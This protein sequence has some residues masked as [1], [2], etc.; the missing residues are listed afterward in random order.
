MAEDDLQAINAYVYD[1]IISKAASEN[2]WE[3][4]ADSAAA[5]RQ[6]F[7]GVSDEM[8]I[9]AIA[10]AN[11]RSSPSDERATLQTVD[12]APAPPE[13]GAVW[14]TDARGVRDQVAEPVCQGRQPMTEDHR[15]PGARC[16]T[17]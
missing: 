10:M 1:E 17:M 16:S 15:R 14:L 3:F 12:K 6:R 2:V 9:D 8:V 5:V 13:K 11:D 4:S 7:P